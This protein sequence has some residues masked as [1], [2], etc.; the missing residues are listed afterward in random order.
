MRH[1]DGG[2]GMAQVARDA[3]IF[4]IDFDDMMNGPPVQDVWMLLPGRMQE[5]S[6]ELE[7]LLAGY[8][9]F[10]P[11]DRGTWGNRSLSGQLRLDL[12]H[13]LAR[14][15]YLRH[16]GA[17]ARGAQRRHRQGRLRH[18]RRLRKLAPRGL[19]LLTQPL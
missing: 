14:R 16:V 12:L 19:N 9:T 4:L 5:A 2:K 6:A 10:R 8:E 18:T 13:R 3:G 17:Q 1:R 15:I 11:F 7:Q